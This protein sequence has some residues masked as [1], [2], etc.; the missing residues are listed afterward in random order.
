MKFNTDKFQVLRMGRHQDIKDG[1]LLFT[2]GME[3]IITQV[4]QVRDLGI[5]MDDI[6]DFKPQLLVAIAKT[7]Q[8]ASLVLRVFRSQ[9]ARILKRLQ[10]SLI[11]PNQDYCS[12]LWFQCGLLRTS[13]LRKCH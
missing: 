13:K 6:G 12:H 8:K 7:R 1:T 3:H 4:D 5:Q 10:R 9:D 2:Q 11:Q